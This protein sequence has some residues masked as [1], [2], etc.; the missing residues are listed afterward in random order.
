MEQKKR[1]VVKHTSEFLLESNQRKAFC[2]QESQKFWQPPRILD[3]KFSMWNGSC[4]MHIK[5]A[6]V[7]QKHFLE[8]QYWGVFSKDRCDN[9]KHFCVSPEKETPLTTRLGRW[10]NC[11]GQIRLL[12]VKMRLNFSKTSRKLKLS[13]ATQTS[14]KVGGKMSFCST[15][16]QQIRRNWRKFRTDKDKSSL[17]TPKGGTADGPSGTPFKCCPHEPKAMFFQAVFGP[18]TSH[19]HVAWIQEAFTS[20]LCLSAYRKDEF[21]TAAGHATEWRLWSINSQELSSNQVNLFP[22]F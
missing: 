5:Q 22:N 10:T 19:D 17:T 7:A 18:S 20:L 16:A 12:T 2:H 11:R 9:K 3:L 8:Y 13:S 1:S 14:G 15:H 4:C 21:S 6:L